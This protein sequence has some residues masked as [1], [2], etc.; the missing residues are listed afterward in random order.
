MIYL[1]NMEKTIYKPAAKSLEPVDPAYVRELV[2]ELFHCKCSERVYL[3]TSGGSAVEL[4]LRAFVQPGSHVVIAGYAQADILS[5]LQALDVSISVV[6]SAY[7]GRLQYAQIEQLVAPDT[8]AIVCAHGCSVSGNVADLE[9]ICTIAR[10]MHL[11]VIADGRLTAGA[12]DVNLEAAGVDVY[13]FTGEKML[14]GPAGIGGICVKDGIETTQ[15]EML[16][17][18]A[19]APQNKT[20]IA[21]AGALEFLLDT[22]MYGITML[23]HRLAKRFYE[24]AKAMNGVSVY[25]DY[26][27]GDRLPAVAIAT[28]GFSAEDIRAYMAAQGILIGVEQG[29]ARFSF[30]YYNTRPQ[31]KE[32]VMQLMELLGIDDPYLL[33]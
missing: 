31:V 17:E 5:V 12:I 1:D 13:C 6:P 4:A 28:E 10:S 3:T 7:N 2:S 9:K 19:Q 30:G 16:M 33:P 27:P 15:L 24:S 23:P 29:M 11:P 14:M 18:C 26:G 21:M 8:C 32:T 22:G 25:G 20:L